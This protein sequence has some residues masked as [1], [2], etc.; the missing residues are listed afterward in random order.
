LT[1]LTN[2][3]NMEASAL[4]RRGFLHLVIKDRMRIEETHKN[5]A[6]ISIQGVFGVRATLTEWRDRQDALLEA[7]KQ[8]TGFQV[9][10]ETA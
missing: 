1:F 5:G 6:K 3:C 4:L 10:G 2:L 7:P 9:N 8:K